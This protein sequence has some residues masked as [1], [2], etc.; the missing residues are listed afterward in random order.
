LFPEATSTWQSFAISY[1]RQQFEVGHLA[2]RS[3][4]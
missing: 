4:F 2:L 3:T 1:P